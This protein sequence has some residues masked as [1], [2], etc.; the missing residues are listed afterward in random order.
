MNKITR[1]SLRLTEDY[2]VGIPHPIKP[3]LTHTLGFVAGKEIAT[4]LRSGAT[5]NDQ[6]ELLPK[7]DGYTHSK[8][9][10]APVA[11]PQTAA[12]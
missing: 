4:V 3:K 6:V 2:T 1:L 9:K 5:R 7:H 8:D 12:T 11:F 10:G